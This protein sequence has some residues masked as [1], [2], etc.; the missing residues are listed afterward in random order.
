MDIKKFIDKAK[1]KIIIKEVDED[2]K[3]SLVK[4]M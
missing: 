3:S 1:D 4:P 2:K